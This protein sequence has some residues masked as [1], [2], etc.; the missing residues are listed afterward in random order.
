MQDLS[1][2]STVLLAQV[3]TNCKSTAITKKDPDAVVL[4]GNKV[5][6][7]ELLRRCAGK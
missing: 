6:R 3:D 1:H 4:K 7:K 5:V 2:C